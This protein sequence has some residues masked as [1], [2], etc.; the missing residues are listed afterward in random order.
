VIR[1]VKKEILNISLN[2]IFLLFKKYDIPTR[3]LSKLVDMENKSKEIR[4]TI[5]TP[6]HIILNVLK[7]N[8]L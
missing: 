3:I 5:F 7:T 2:I 8:L 1:D 6:F 4:F